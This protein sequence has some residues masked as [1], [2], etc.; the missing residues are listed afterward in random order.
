MRSG[1]GSFPGVISETRL[2]IF[3]K[4]V[5]KRFRCC[6]TMKIGNM[7]MLHECLYSAVARYKGSVMSAKKS[8]HLLELKETSAILWRTL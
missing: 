6:E 4:K 3:C 8:P 7:I 5:I 2:P 1:F